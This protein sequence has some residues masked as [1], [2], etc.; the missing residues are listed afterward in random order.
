MLATMSQ[1]QLS[2]ILD[3]LD[4]MEKKLDDVMRFLSANMRTASSNISSCTPVE[5]PSALTESIT[6]EVAVNIIFALVMLIDSS[7]DSLDGYAGGLFIS[8]AKLRAC[9]QS[10]ADDLLQRAQGLY[11]AC[12]PAYEPLPAS[13]LRTALPGFAKRITDSFRKKASY[14]VLSA[15][16]ITVTKLSDCLCTLVKCLC[17][18]FGASTKNAPHWQLVS[19]VLKE[20]SRGAMAM[21]FAAPV[22]EDSAAVRLLVLH[23]IRDEEPYRSV[24]D[25]LASENIERLYQVG[26]KR[27]RESR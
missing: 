11:L 27:Q 14:A 8:E 10:A 16:E 25:D 4:N 5:S 15:S 18:S 17:R 12:T 24:L 20:M 13:V 1:T 6:P 19:A 9:I 2:H 22:G 23:Q 3:R 21:M 7:S 26:N